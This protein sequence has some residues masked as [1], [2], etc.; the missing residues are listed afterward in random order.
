MIS[1]KLVDE[2]GVNRRP[3]STLGVEHV[4]MLTADGNRTEEIQTFQTNM[5]ADLKVFE[6]KTE[7]NLALMELNQQKANKHIE[8]MKTTQ[9][10][11]AQMARQCRRFARGLN[12]GRT[13]TFSFDGSRDDSMEGG[14]PEEDSENDSEGESGSG[15]EEEEDTENVE[16]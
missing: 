13:M 15:N 5:K 8:R 16:K 7:N 10:E 4:Y 11:M 14:D 3:L 2:I 12:A 6:E 1:G 9:T